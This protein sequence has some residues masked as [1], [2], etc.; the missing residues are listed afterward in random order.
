MPLWDEILPDKCITLCGALVH[1]VYTP[2][3]DT[4]GTK[5]TKKVKDETEPNKMTTI[6]DPLVDGPHQVC[7]LTLLYF[8]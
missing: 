8:G 6:Q 7:L 2:P 1:Y 5:T 3:D 4:D